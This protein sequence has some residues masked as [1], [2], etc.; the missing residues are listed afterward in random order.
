MKIDKLI[1]PESYN[2]TQ[3]FFLGT[4][5]NLCLSET[6]DSERVNYLNPLNGLNELLE[7]YSLGDKYSAPT[8]RLHLVS[9]LLSIFENDQNLTN[10][11]FNETNL[12][13]TTLLLDIIND[14]SLDDVAKINKLDS[15]K[16][17]IISLS[18]ELIYKLESNYRTI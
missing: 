6:L 2:E 17:L 15:N 9:E 11:A 10:P 4:W 5:Y 8:K 14:V 16:N 13:I 3:Q 1:T 7:L 12:K 18:K